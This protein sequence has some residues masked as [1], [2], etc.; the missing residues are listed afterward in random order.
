MPKNTLCP[1]VL[2]AHSPA[3]QL[4]C[5]GSLNAPAPFTGRGLY[6]LPLNVVNL[7]TSPFQGLV[8]SQILLSIQLPLTIYLQFRLT[9]SRAVMGEFVNSAWHNFVLGVISVVVVGLNILLLWD[10]LAG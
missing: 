4:N 3:V 2:F 5:N 8:V 6:A 7:Q 9:A 10:T 1:P